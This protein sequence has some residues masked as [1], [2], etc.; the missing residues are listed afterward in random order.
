MILKNSELKLP[1][2]TAALEKPVSF[3][4]AAGRSVF[5]SGLHREN[6]AEKGF[7]AWHPNSLFPEKAGIAGWSPV[8]DASEG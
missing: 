1:S 6:S 7:Y 4:S 2:L 3:R 8:V 5:P